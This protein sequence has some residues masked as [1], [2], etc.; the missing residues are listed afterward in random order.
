[1]A[2]ATVAALIQAQLVPAL[3]GALGGDSLASFPLPAFDLSE[4]VPGL[5]PGS[6]LAI[7]PTDLVRDGGNTY[8]LG[9]LADT[10]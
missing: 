9:V 10:P 1:A 7:E 5:P 3:L 8:V 6:V 4:S 2:E